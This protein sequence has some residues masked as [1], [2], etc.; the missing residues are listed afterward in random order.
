VVRI[1]LDKIKASALQVVDKTLQLEHNPVYTQNTD[2]FASEKQKWSSYYTGLRQRHFRYLINPRV[3]EPSESD[4]DT[5]NEMV[6]IAEDK[7]Q[8]ALSVMANVRAYFQVTYKVND[9]SVPLQRINI[10]FV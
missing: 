7:F 5:D 3:I 2:F 8:Q 4:D 9:P 6:R 1:E 10:H